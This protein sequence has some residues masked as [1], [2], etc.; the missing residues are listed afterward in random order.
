VANLPGSLPAALVGTLARDLDRRLW[1]VIAS[2]P[3]RRRR[4]RRTWPRCWTGT[5]ALYP[6]R[7]ALPFEAEDHHIEVSGQRVEALEAL[8]A[9]RVRVLVTTSRAIQE[10]ER[11]PDGL[12]DLRFTVDGGPGGATGEL[13]ERLDAMGFE[14]TGLVE[15]VGEYAARGGIVDLFSFGSEDPS[16]SSSGAT[17]SPPSAA[18]TSWTSAPPRRWSR[19]DILPVELKLA[20]GG[21]GPGARC[22]TCCPRDTLLVQLH[23]DDDRLFRTR[24]RSCWS[25]T[26]WRSDGAG[27][28]SRRTSSSCRPIRRARAARPLRPAWCAPRSG[29]LRFDAARPRPSTGTPRASPLLHAA[30]ARGERTLILCDNTGQ[31]ER[32]DELLGG[33]GALPARHRPGPGHPERRLRPRG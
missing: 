33:A 16:A 26:P 6:Q 9:G 32:L 15:Q 11:I 14:R 31:L 2:D 28:R 4:W 13:A 5:G 30:A 8:L 17:R 7:E 12:A 10:Q 1:V 22:W 23:Q 25:C 24:G 18:S 20:G 19:A 21:R 29:D 3:R 27:S